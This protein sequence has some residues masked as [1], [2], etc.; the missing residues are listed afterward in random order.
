MPRATRYIRGAET[1]GYRTPTAAT[2]RRGL[3]RYSNC[4]R[5]GENEDMTTAAA[6]LF[7]LVA[8]GVIAFQLA[9]AL[10]APWGAYA[11]G[12]KFPGRYPRSMRVAALGQA[13]VLALLALIVLSE[14]GL[15]LPQIA[16]AAPWAIW[17]V[18]LFS[19]VSVVLNLITPSA[20]ERRIWVP[21]A[22][23]MLVS[24]LTVALTSMAGQ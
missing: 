11:M 18:V 17:L 23:I 5:E 10:G 7:V 24:S 8:T 16:G 19:A 14:A 22:V 13:A 9:L 2:D 15:V 20:G 6:A 12:G 4:P 1:R 21:V 3:Q